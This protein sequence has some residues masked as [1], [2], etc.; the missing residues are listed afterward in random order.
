MIPRYAR[1]EMTAIW[2]PETRFRIWYEIEAHACD[3]QADLGVIPRENAEA[4]WKA[5]DVEFDVARID[6]IEAVTKHDVIAF[7]THLAE[8][9]GAEEARFVHQGMTSSDVLD[10][11]LNVQLVRAADI[12][13]ADMDKVLAAL[14]KRAY[15]HKN[16]VRIGRSHGIHAEPTTMGL[17][18]ARFY[19]EMARGRE[20]LERARDEVATGAISGAVGTFANIDPRVEE[21]VCAKMGLSPEPISTQV[22]PRDRH[23]M[24]FATLG[25]IASS[26]EN[27]AIEIRHMQRTEVLEAEEYFSPGQKG[28]SAMPHK[29]NP[30]LTE[31]LTGLA[32]L[33]RMAVVPAMENV[34]LWHERDISHSSVERGIAPD[35][36]ITLDFALNRLAGV[37]EKL[38]VYPENML[39]NMNKFK[40]LVMSQRVLLALTQAGVSREDAYRLV[41][42][43]AMKVWEQGADFKTE[44]LADAEV[45]AALSPA[46]I[47]EKFDL[48]Y[49]T[50]HVD[51]IF[52]RV[53]GENGAH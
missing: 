35:A 46:E 39:K 9:I 4:V 38:V 43:N 23:A 3:A 27:I 26:I 41:Q 47:E 18:F 33:V 48:G 24:F 42:R 5:R 52:A 28:S 51:T 34:A 2:S 8:H 6:E 53:F 31:N 22:I 44:L 16:T 7:L 21:H 1:P 30:V 12:L 50:K 14:K 19:A 20:R 17:T 25:V 36:T 10:T 11:T 49:H 32:R 37:I 29:R 40:G 45:T 13:L 15:E